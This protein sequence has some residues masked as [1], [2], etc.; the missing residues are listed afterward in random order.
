MTKAGVLG[1]SVLWTIFSASALPAEASPPFTTPSK[2]DASRFLEVSEGVLLY[3]CDIAAKPI[4][5]K[6]LDWR[7][8]GTA[9]AIRKAS[10]K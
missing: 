8:V 5:S 6:Q 3:F 7:L 1:F 4:F 10:G 9:G 2:K